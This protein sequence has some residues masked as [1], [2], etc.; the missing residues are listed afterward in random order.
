MRT[1]QLL[2][3]L[4]RPFSP[5]YSF[6]MVLREKM[7]NANIFSSY[8]SKVPVISVGNLTLGGTGKTP[9]V[10]WLAQFLQGESYTP[11]IISRG[12][13]GTAKQLVNVV[14]DGKQILL[15]QKA[16]GDE[17]YMLATAMKNIAVVT[18]KKRKY[19][20][21]YAVKELG[22]DLL[23]L[24]DG[25]Q[26]LAVKRDLNI[27]LFNG[28]TL[29]GNSRVFPGGELREPVASLHRAD[30]FVITGIDD[31]IQD[32]ATRFRELL[33]SR[34]PETPVF[35]FGT[36][37]SGITTLSGDTVSLEELKSPMVAFS[38]IAHPE[39]FHTSLKS[40]NLDIT[41]TLVFD[42][43]TDYEAAFTK[44]ISD[45]AVNCGALALI[46]TE[47]D[48]VKLTAADFSL[49][50]YVVKIEVDVPEQFISYL[51]DQ[52]SQIQEK[53]KVHAG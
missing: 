13:R 53:R 46:T 40:H 36:K 11:A 21:E 48:S 45:Q 6:L 1:N 15:K 3:T 19:P 7:F 50:L 22:A 8:S 14:S 38:G 41:E 4:G 51:K 12:Y 34:F 16:A 5:I 31:N 29:A 25:F 9:V 10:L 44:K 43:H 30:A 39:R 32:R 37:I 42:D 2:F 23:L 49:P 26:H 24:D 52:L 47:K 27:V 17:P 18:G 20:C 33:E 28:F 35:F